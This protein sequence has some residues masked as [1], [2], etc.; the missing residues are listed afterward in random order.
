MRPACEAS[1]VYF[2]K[3]RNRDGMQKFLRDRAMSPHRTD[4][5]RVSAPCRREYHPKGGTAPDLTPLTLTS[6]TTCIN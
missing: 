2:R 1:L 6:S 3:L 5:A 4:V